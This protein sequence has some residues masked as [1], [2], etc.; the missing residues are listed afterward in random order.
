M[1]F[2]NI[3]DFRQQIS[4]YPADGLK[5][6]H[7][8]IKP[9]LRDRKFQFPIPGV[10][11]EVLKATAVFT[12]KYENTILGNGFQDCNLILVQFNSGIEELQKSGCYGTHFLR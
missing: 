6:K 10:V 8:I 4:E 7:A 11:K 2:E 9:D 5:G 1:I 12:G 3:V